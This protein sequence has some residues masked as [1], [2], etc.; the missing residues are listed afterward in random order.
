MST[1]WRNNLIFMESWYR[2][3]AAAAGPA[4][5]RALAPENYRRNHFLGIADGGVHVF[6]VHYEVRTGTFEAF[7]FGGRMSGPVYMRE[8]LSEGRQLP[9][10]RCS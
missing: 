5:R 4:G 9:N 3:V 8:P 6:H 7:E 10:V 1:V 2:S